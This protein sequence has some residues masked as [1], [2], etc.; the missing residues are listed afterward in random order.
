M[1]STAVDRPPAPSEDIP[2]GSLTLQD[3]TMTMLW[4]E[5]KAL[6]AGRM[7]K[8][9]EQAEQA[10]ARM[11]VGH[12]LGLNP[13]QSMLGIDIVKGHAQ[14]RGTLLGTLV[15]SREGYDWK[16]KSMGAEGVA[17]EFFRNGESEGVSEWG[18][19][20]SKLAELDKPTSNGAKSNHI[21][22]PVAMFW[23]RAM[24]QGV[25][26]LVPETMR[27]IPVYT[28]EDL[29]G[30][31]VGGAR[32]GEPG[33]TGGRASGP[34]DRGAL[35]DAIIDNIPLE[36]QERAKDLVDEQNSLAAGS[37]S[38][39]KIELVFKGKSVYA[40]SV[41]LS[42]IENA[43]DELRATR[44]APLQ[45]GDAVEDAEV[46]ADL[47]VTD[48]GEPPKEPEA[49]A[50][51]LDTA[52]RIRTQRVNELEFDLAEADLTDQQRSD[53]EAE[54]DSLTAPPPSEVDGGQV[55]LEL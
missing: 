37:W 1:T 5:A 3:A 46:V 29:E 22:Y 36:Q 20:Q 43:I 49:T 47:P 44:P 42:A 30:L 53:V 15:R 6:S 8:D 32:D 34:E 12:H 35:L 23:N 14:L 9:V 51:E 31:P 17:I 40:T 45:V 54:L 50:E 19:E 18:P 7:F 25:K 27:G 26:L 24:S 55:E 11:L 52:E 48:D 16:V 39:S 13:A 33:G 21:K 38:A 2:Q 10:F 28:P 4:R 41:E